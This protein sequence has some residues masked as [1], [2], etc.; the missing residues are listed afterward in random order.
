MPIM[1]GL[2]AVKKIREG[3]IPGQEAI[4]I[5]ALTAETNLEELKMKE[6]KLSGVQSKPFNPDELYRDMVLAVKK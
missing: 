3:E 6:L 5:I 1:D 4:P 2:E